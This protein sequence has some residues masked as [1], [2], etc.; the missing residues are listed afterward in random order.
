MECI[1]KNS[2]GKHLFCDEELI[3]DGVIVEVF[4]DKN[5]VTE[6]EINDFVDNLYKERDV[7]KHT[8]NKLTNIKNLNGYELFQIFNEREN[9][10]ISH[11][12]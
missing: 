11:G 3:E 7:V 12:I 9:L 4:A 8:V 10:D 5:M 6:H 2:N 1:D